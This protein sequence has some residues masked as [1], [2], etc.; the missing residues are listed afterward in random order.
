M[1]FSPSF[2]RDTQFRQRKQNRRIAVQKTSQPEFRSFLQPGRLRLVA[3][4]AAHQLQQKLLPQ[5]GLVP[6]EL[7]SHLIRFDAVQALP[8]HFLLQFLKNFSELPA[9]D[10]LEQIVFRPALK[11]RFRI[12]KIFVS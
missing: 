11:G 4:V 7:R 1:R 12:V 10:R 9:Y 6:V 2:R 5:H 3:D 8:V